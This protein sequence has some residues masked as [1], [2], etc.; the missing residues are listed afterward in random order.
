MYIIKAN[1]S[2]QNQKCKL[3]AKT[4]VHFIMKFYTKTYRLTENLKNMFCKV[5]E[6]LRSVN[7]G[8][9]THIYL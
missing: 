3:K 4:L 8:D 2:L 9:K 5:P 1:A 6:V 7:N